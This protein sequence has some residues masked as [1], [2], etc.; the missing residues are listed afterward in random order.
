[1]EKLRGQ[2]YELDG[3]VVPDAVFHQAYEGKYDAVVCMYHD[4]GLI[5]FKMLHFR[6][7]VN[8][9]LGLPIIRTSPDHGV[10]FD[11]V[12]KGLA[13]PASMLAAIELAYEMAEIKKR[14]KEGS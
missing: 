7:G 1:L 13:D 3:P 8:V 12:G 6:D 9:T 4:Q 10:A 2:G 11:I 14:K 5:P